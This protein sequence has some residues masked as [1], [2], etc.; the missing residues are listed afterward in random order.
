MG[1]QVV[2]ATGKQPLRI[3][4]TIDGKQCLVSNAADGTISIYDTK[5][6][7]QLTTISIPG[8]NSIYER[9]IYR[10]PRPVG[11]L[12]HPNGKYAFVSNYSAARVE[13]LDMDSLTLV[14]SIKSGEMPDGL[15][16]IN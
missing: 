8:K 7:K 12:M 16:F 5:T 14:S 15:A 13:V 9:A 2:V 3:A 1:P 4:F 6:R 10:T 11:I